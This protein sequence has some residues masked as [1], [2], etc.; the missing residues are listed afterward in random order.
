MFKP[1]RGDADIRDMPAALSRTERTRLREL[2]DAVERELQTFYEVVGNALMEIRDARLYR[3]THPTFE[4]YLDER[5]S[6]TRGRGYQLIDA[7]AV[8]TVVDAAGLPLPANERQARAL[9]PLWR[10]DKE[11]MLDVYRE[12]HEEHGDALTADIIRAQYASEPPDEDSDE[13]NDGES[14]RYFTLEKFVEASRRALGHIDLDPATCDEAQR[15]VQADTA[16]SWDD[17]EEDGTELPWKGRVFLNPPFSEGAAFGKLLK[18]FYESGDVTAAVMVA[19]PRSAGNAWFRWF[20]QWPWIKAKR[21]VFYRPGGRREDPFGWTIFVGVGIPAEQL[22]QAFDGLGQI[23]MPPDARWLAER[24]E[25]RLTGLPRETIHLLDIGLL[26]DDVLGQRLTDARTQLG[27]PLGG[28]VEHVD[29][30]P[31][32]LERWLDAQ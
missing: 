31:D 28:Y 8:S 26:E 22:A 7:A 21:P 15:I 14:D 27:I 12:L 4:A 10:E 32:E 16:Y 19:H 5:W 25:E 24:G 2:E 18:D 29:A 13:E 20:D 6:I 1:T 9:V 3:E 17:R 11:R 23:Q 30:L